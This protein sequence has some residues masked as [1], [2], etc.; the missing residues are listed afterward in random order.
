MSPLS[1]LLLVLSATFAAVTASENVLVLTE[2]NFDEVINGN[3][4][5]LVKFYAPW[6]GHCK[7]LA[8]KYDEA[9]DLLNGEGSTIRLAKV[10][11]TENQALATKYEVRGYPTI[12]YFKNGKPT[13]Y[14]G[15]RSTSQIVD[16]V[17]KKGGPSVI[18]VESAEQLKELTEK[19]KVLVLGTFKDAKSEAAAVYNEVA[20]SVDDIVFGSFSDAAVLAATGLNTDGVALIRTDGDDSETSSI[21]ESEITNALELKKWIHGH[22]LAPVTEFTQE[23]AQEIVG[24]DL[25]QFHFLLIRRSDSTFDETLAKFTEVAKLFR[26]KVVFVLLDVDISESARILEFLGV[27]ADKTPTNRIVN[28]ADQVDKFKPVDGQGYEDFTNSFLDGKA[29]LDLKSEELPQDWN[30]QPVK[31]LV[32]SNFHEIAGDQKK[33]VFVKFYAPW[34]GHCKQLVPVWD[35]LAKKY[36]SNENVVIAKMDSTL[37]ELADVTIN[38]FPTLKIWPAGSSTPVDYDG[39]RNLEKFSEFVDKYATAETA[40]QDHEEL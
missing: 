21:E 35:E 18:S 27:D 28:L 4:F 20:E 29:A 8:P 3:E 2:S 6:C 33:T 31:K 38:S 23:S 40:S 32:A 7:S 10:D 26:S 15:G 22:K 25:K 17:K 30:D 5:V 39:D 13:K 14:T 34:C 9:A 36:E 19:H 11:A 12:L 37:N 24:G 1:S 16:W